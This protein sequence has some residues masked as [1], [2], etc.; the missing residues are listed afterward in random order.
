M[1]PIEISCPSKTFILGEYG[2]LDGGVAILANT[3]PRFSCLMYKKSDIKSE[4]FSENHT[5][6]Q[7]ISKYSKEF[8][9]MCLEWK[10]PYDSKGG[11][12]FSS[13]QFNILY[14]YSLICRKTTIEQIQLKDL[15]ETYHQI[16]FEG[17]VPSGA[18]IISQWVGG[19]CLFEQDPFLVQSIVFPF[20]ELDF[21]II[22][23]GEHLQTHQ[24]LKTLKL[25]KVEDLKNI[26]KSGLKAIENN[27]DD[28]F[29]ECINE[30]GKTLQ[31]KKLVAEKTL[32]YL[33][34]LKECKEI[35]ALKGCGA[36]GAEIIILFYKK[37][38]ASIVKQK[39][40]P[41]KF[42]ADSSNLTYGIESHSSVKTKSY[43]KTKEA[44]L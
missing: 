38:H 42:I 25:P 10:D 5:I 9:G 32:K 20:S 28:I 31:S 2:V 14:Y 37:E 16:Q 27:E 21:A 36:M 44:I 19:I 30:Y 18:D 29:L 35:L 34:E 17:V 39:I 4:Y 26:A 13:A 6:N 33:E 40:T 41:F 15:L 8:Q 3:A 23:I 22:R 7:W 24:H 1:N 11:L 43:S 12:G